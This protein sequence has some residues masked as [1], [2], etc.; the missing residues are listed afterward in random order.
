MPLSSREISPMQLPWAKNFTKVW[1]TTEK[2]ETY[3]NNT[4][5]NLDKNNKKKAE[6]SLTSWIG[7]NA[8]SQA[9]QKKHYPKQYKNSSKDPNRQQKQSIE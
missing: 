1:S 7:N 3:D 6:Q 8:L 4:R 2:Q 9:I 5:W